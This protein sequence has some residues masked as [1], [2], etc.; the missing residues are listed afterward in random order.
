MGK[1]LFLYHHH[2][3]I[4][5]EPAKAKSLRQKWWQSS[6]RLTWPRGSAAGHCAMGFSPIGWLRAW[7]VSEDISAA[8]AWS[9]TGSFSE[10]RPRTLQ[11]GAGWAAALSVDSSPEEQIASSTKHIH[12]QPCLCCQESI[13]EGK[14]SL[15][16]QVCYILCREVLLLS[17]TRRGIYLLLIHQ[18]T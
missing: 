14:T 7:G 4:T 16:Q 13:Q 2:S 8:E 3:R 17:I 15:Q 12:V 1:C 10:L 11:S 18:K 5:S 9:G 6:P